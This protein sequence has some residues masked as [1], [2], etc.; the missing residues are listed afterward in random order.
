MLWTSEWF[1]VVLILVA[2][3]WDSPIIIKSASWLPI[4]SP[5]LR[6]KSPSWES[7]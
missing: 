4:T 2:R 7:S 3:D 1:N 5:A 6:Q